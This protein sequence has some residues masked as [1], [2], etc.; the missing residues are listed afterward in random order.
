MDITYSSTAVP[1]GF[2]WSIIEFCKPSFEW[3]LSGAFSP[4]NEIHLC[5]AKDIS[6]QILFPVKWQELNNYLGL[7]RAMSRKINVKKG[8]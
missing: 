2:D 1:N 6:L 8:E 7:F 4:L 3:V 5:R